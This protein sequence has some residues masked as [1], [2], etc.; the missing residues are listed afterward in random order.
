MLNSLSIR[1]VVLIERL[2]LD[3]QSGLCV[4]TGETGAGKSILLDALGLALGQRAEARLVRNGSSQAT[5]TAEFKLPEKHHLKEVL[6]EQGLDADDG[7]L[8]LRRVLGTDGRSRAFVNDQP[9]GVS[10]L[11][12][13]GEDL[14]EI[15]GQFESQR[16]L[17][18]ARHRGLLDAFGS[19]ASAQTK[20]RKTFQVFQEIVK[21]RIALEKEFEE[22]QRDEEYIRH[23]ISE[24]SAINPQP[25]EEQQLADQRSVMMH[26][27]KIGEALRDA[28]S[29][30]DGN[31]GAIENIQKSVRYLE[32][33]AEKADGQLEPIIE[34]L[35][36]ALDE[37]S[38]GSAL[39]ARTA[40]DLDFS[41]GRLEEAE[42]RLFALRAMARKHNVMVDQLADLHLEYMNKL[43]A[44]EDGSASISALRE[45][46]TKARWAFVSEAKNLSEKRRVSAKKLDASVTTEL[47]ELRLGKSV[48]TTVI[49]EKPEASWDG[50]G[51]DS[52]SF[53]V[54]TNPGA[55]AGPI[56]KIASGGE[57]SRFMLA[58]KAVLAGADSIPTLVF[59]E[60]DAGIGGAVAAAVGKRLNRLAE[61]FQVLVVTHSP[62]VAALGT[63]HWQVSKSETK[64]GV[65]TS[66]QTLDQGERQEEIA[67]MLAGASIT[68]EARAAAG[69]LL[70]GRGL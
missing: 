12:R 5:V 45:A 63:H 24:L 69:S 51:A 32:R 68:E 28:S 39:L 14:V 25:N 50:E 20:T 27:E 47:E 34:T 35:M 65:V 7:V 17:N 58:L 38:D 60:V 43:S 56:N 49:E 6:V 59:D 15:H 55:P 18:P 26:G 48:F 62:Q 29:I 44:V 41:P 19:H 61:K 46:E 1:D 13:I 3:F 11:K 40:S 37:A 16:L 70:D 10:L 33:V 54:S 42:E 67:R 4:L 2:D 52:I 30:L 57:L 64:T 22:A 53:Q 66:V 21:K 8:I 9:V 36:R 23:A 31:R